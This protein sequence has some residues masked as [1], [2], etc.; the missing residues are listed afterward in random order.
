MRETAATFLLSQR[1]GLRVTRDADQFG[2]EEVFK[3]GVA[4]DLS[5]IRENRLTIIS[6]PSLLSPR[7]SAR[8]EAEGQ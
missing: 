8:R 7:P 1:T 3:R 6:H 2:I 4:P 5:E